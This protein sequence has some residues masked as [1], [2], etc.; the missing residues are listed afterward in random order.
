[1]ADLRAAAS[2]GFNAAKIEGLVKTQRETAGATRPE[3]RDELKV[4]RYE[5]RA[6]Y[7][8]TD[9]TPLITAA[10]NHPQQLFT[11]P[12]KLQTRFFSCYAY[13]GCP[14]GRM[15]ESRSRP[16]KDGP[17]GCGH[18]SQTAGVTGVPS[19]APFY[20]TERPAMTS[21]ATF[22]KKS[23]P[24]STPHPHPGHGRYQRHR[25]NHCLHTNAWQVIASN[26]NHHRRGTGR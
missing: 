7:F 2:S 26:A 18:T 5:K 1:M 12:T 6:L 17:I 25:Y 4:I 13:Y 23:L 22:Y 10:L 3:I 20:A 16:L 8:P 19:R 9:H 24:I 15:Q 21:S 14:L 11:R